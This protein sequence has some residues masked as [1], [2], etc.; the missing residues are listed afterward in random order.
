MSSTI[1]KYQ[2][3]E[4]VLQGVSGGN[5]QVRVQFPD[6]PYLRNRKIMGIDIYDFGSVTNSPAQ[7]APATIA[8][9]KTAF[10]TLYLNDPGAPTDLGEWINLVPLVRFNNQ[11]SPGVATENFARMPFN[12]VGQSVQWEKCYITLAAPLAN[13]AN[14][15]FLFGIYFE[16]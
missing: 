8:N 13:T 7:N 3:V 14:V 5:Q 12:M 10:L 1:K 15:S 2:L 9:L 6:Q 11:E 4:V 16:G